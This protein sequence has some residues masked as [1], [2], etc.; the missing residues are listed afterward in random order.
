[1]SILDHL[2]LGLR[3]RLPMILQTEAAEC[4]LACLGMIAGFHDFR[5][6]LPT[7]RSRFSVSLKGT[8]LDSL[9]RMAEV[10][11]LGTRPVKLDIDQLD[12]LTL[13]CILH[14]N[15][16]HFVVLH[17]I[18]ARQ[19]VIHDPAYGV[20]SVGQ[21]ELSRCFTGVAL[22]LWPA[23]GFEPKAAPPSLALRSLL[24]SVTGLSRAF[25]QVLALALALELF[26]IVAPFYMQWT[27][28]YALVAA[29]RN[30]LVTLAVGFALVMLLR[31]GTTALRGWVLMY[32][33]TQLNVQWRANLF[34]HLVRLPVQYFERRH[35]GDVVSRF[36]S[37]D[38]IQRTLTSSFL[39]A[40]LDGLMTIATLSMM[41][42]YSPALTA[43]AFSCIV[44]YGL[45]RLAWY[46]PFHAATEAQ[47]VHTAKQQSHF[48]ETVRGV[49]AIKLF[50]RYEQR[51]ASWLTL[52]VDQVNAG[53]H[54]QKMQLY[55]YLLNGVLFGGTTILIVWLGAN[56]VLDGQFSVGLLT[57]FIAYKT[58]FD[59]RV[60]ALID[61]YLDLRMLRLQGARLADIALTMPETV[62]GTP[63]SAA[64]HSAPSIDISG[65]RFRYAEHEPY[66]LDGVSMHIGAGES[67]ALVGPSGCG[68]TTLLNIMLG[69]LTPTEGEITIGGRSLRQTGVDG[70][71]QLVGTVLQDDMLFAGS[72]RDNI[73]FFDPNADHAWV[74][75]CAR[76]AAIDAEIAA[77][78]MAYDTLVGDMGTVLSGGQKQRVLLARA[79]YKRPAILFLDEATSHLDIGK[80][81]EVNDAI[82]ALDITR[83]IVAHRPETIASASRVIY[84]EGGKLMP[85]P[86]SRPLSR[87]ASVA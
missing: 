57:A 13:P 9:I 5:T 10:L 71:R 36:G 51:R 1:M 31:Q 22:E 32:M 67:V 61:K 7:L 49:R 86:A 83:V 6:D 11:K 33:S 59:T 78:P 77:M 46:R 47:I 82:R 56:L 70:L 3:R 75:H 4:G 34:S 18:N 12:N 58:Q 28:D 81:Q 80:E 72:I 35:I 8:T 30:L 43:I 41:Y 66:V 74:V 16:N 84:L 26:A 21:E 20:R 25:L 23:P 19:A 39:E 48:L 68:K 44:L 60:S 17:K 2:S 15:F 87:P 45:A 42:L 52:L 27:I 64:A 53:L 24:G 38:Q 37:L 85:L 76:L 40:I 54:I 69:I 62:Y 73:S 55:F 65:V 63:D 14:W 29:D 50:Q 79:L